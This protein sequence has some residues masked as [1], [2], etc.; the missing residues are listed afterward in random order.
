MIYLTSWI[1]YPPAGSRHPIPSCPLALSIPVPTS[2]SSA[3]SPLSERLRAN[4]DSPSFCLTLNICITPEVTFAYYPS[5]EP[6]GL[7]CKWLALLRN[8]CAHSTQSS[9]QSTQSTPCSHLNY[10]GHDKVADQAWLTQATPTVMCVGVIEAVAQC[11]TRRKNPRLL[12]Q[13]QWETTTGNNSL[14]L[15]DS[16]RALQGGFRSEATASPPATTTTAIATKR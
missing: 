4:V 5:T 11:N 14:H 2:S 10:T 6:P 7:A 8:L 1:E 16:G 3:T 13:Q 12:L 15:E 9:T